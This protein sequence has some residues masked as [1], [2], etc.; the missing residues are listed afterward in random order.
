MWTILV[1][2]TTEVKKKSKLWRMSL[3]KKTRSKKTSLSCEEVKRYKEY[4]LNQTR[5][6]FLGVRSIRDRTITQE[7]IWLVYPPHLT[8]LAS[9]KSLDFKPLKYKNSYFV[10]SY[11]YCVLR[12][13]FGYFL[14][15][16]SD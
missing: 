13:Y 7:S 1:K 16:D 9:E 12:S 5:N 2:Q 10:R 6:T 4:P 3:I 15:E 11:H 8:L 14:E